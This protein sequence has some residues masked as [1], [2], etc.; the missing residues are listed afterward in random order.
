MTNPR[1]ITLIVVGFIAMLFSVQYTGEESVYTVTSYEMWYHEQ[2]LGPTLY[3]EPYRRPPLINWLIIGFAST[4]G[5]EYSIA[6]V[7]LVSAISTFASAVLIFWFLRRGKAS[8]DISLLGALIYLSMWQIIGGYGWKGY[9]DALFG[10]CTFAAMLYSYLSVKETSYRW[11][12]VAIVFAYLGFL[13]KALTSFV[14]L[15]SALF[16][17][18]LIDKKLAY[19]GKVLLP[20]FVVLSGLL[21]WCWYAIAPTGE[22]MA[23]GM[24]S[25]IV[26][27]YLSIDFSVFFSH[28]LVFPFE[29]VLNLLPVSAFLLYLG[30]KRKMPLTPNS[31]VKTLGL[32]ALIGFLPYWIAPS[33]HSRYLM[34]IYGIVAIYFTLLIQDDLDLIR[35]VRKFIVW[36]VLFKLAFAFVLFPA[37]TKA[38]RPPIDHWA[39]NVKE[40]V[41]DKTLYSVDQTWIGISV[42][43]TFNRLIYPRPPVVRAYGDVE[44]GYILSNTNREDLGVLV[45]SFDNK[46]FLYCFGVECAK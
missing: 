45:K 2:W 28:L 38:F 9:S 20:V 36:I 43:D 15:F 4:I 25:D 33:S 31:L 26:D 24:F 21:I 18:A 17:T 35:R 14:F 3:G 41:A 11:L 30:F 23:T 40:I 12:I 27:R 7:R 46:L 10:A 6:A 13:T 34:P 22:Q 29:T 16:I 44:S 5:W 37:Y 1:L 8:I 19:L 42:V 39:Q 32:I